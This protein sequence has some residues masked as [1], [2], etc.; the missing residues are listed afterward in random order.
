MEFSIEEFNEPSKSFN[1]NY[2]KIGKLGNGAFGKVYKAKEI[3]TE[4]IVAVKQISINNS[5]IK[6]EYILKEIN[7]LSNLSHPNIVKYYKH[8]EENDKIY[9]IMEYLEGGT[10]KQYINEE[11]NKINEDICRIIIKKILEALS[12]LHYTCDICHRDIKPENIMFK[13]NNDPNSVKL[14][15]FGLSSDSFEKKNYLDNCGTLIYMAPEQISNKTYSKSVDIW[16]VGIILYMLLN[17]GKNPFY[18]KGESREKII[19]KITSK[20]V[21]FDDKNYPISEIGKHFINK[22]L[23]KNSS[24]RYTA[25]PALKHPWITMKK[26]EE[27]P[28]TVLDKLLTG[29]YVKIIKEL[30]L[31]SLFMNYYKKNKFYLNLNYNNINNINNI[32]FEGSTRKACYTSHSHVKQ[33]KL[34][35]IKKNEINKNNNLVDDDF[36]LDEYFQRVKKSNLLL[37]KKFKENREIM[38]MTKKDTNNIINKNINTNVNIFGKSNNKIEIKDK[39]YEDEKSELDSNILKKKKNNIIYNIKNKSNK[40]I[41]KSPKNKII[42]L[43]NNE[44]KKIK[45]IISDIDVKNSRNKKINNKNPPNNINHIFRQ[46]ESKKENNII[47][48]E[49]KTLEEF[50]TKEKTNRNKSVSQY[51][52]LY[53]TDNLKENDI[54]NKY[55]SKDIYNNDILN[56]KLFLKDTQNQNSKNKLIKKNSCVMT[57]RNK[58]DIIKNFKNISNNNKIIL[59]DKNKNKS[60]ENVKCNNFNKNIIKNIKMNSRKKSSNKIGK[61]NY[62]SF[63]EKNNNKFNYNLVKKNNDNTTLINDNIYNLFNVENKIKPK[64]LLFEQKNKILP[65]IDIKNNFC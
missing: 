61:Y 45:N 50:I 40:I 17:N 27:I 60:T 12:Y 44:K 28:M 49:L 15:D 29:S 32:S 31:T 16:S 13:Y 2:I 59:I 11:K 18:N 30:F 57:Q 56:Y 54:Y 8:Y 43:F 55:N 46:S 37:E 7:V 20:K 1:H 38:F 9:I 63:S 64:K 33:N 34:N 52:R 36:D 65:K 3:K 51:N 6:Y 10:L 5:K 47:K 21:E 35:N 14:I 48:P 24:S 39:D 23:M 58:I 4:K 53:I 26:F 41:N 19:E 42:K 22:L 62:Y 25:R